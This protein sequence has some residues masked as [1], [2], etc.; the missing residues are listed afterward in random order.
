[1]S[2]PVIYTW[3]DGMLHSTNGSCGCSAAR[4]NPICKCGEVLHTQGSYYGLIMS[5]PQCD[6]ES[7]GSPPENLEGAERE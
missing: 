4:G 7:W 6:A 5:C 3:L 1:M 2:E